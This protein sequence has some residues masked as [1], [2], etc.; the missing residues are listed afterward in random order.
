M[1][2]IIAFLMIISLFLVIG[3]SS[4]NSSES[5]SEPVLDNV[6]VMENDVEDT[7]TP[8]VVEPE[9][10]VDETISVDPTV[11]KLADKAASVKSIY[12]EYNEFK[13]GSTGYFAYVW[14]KDD[15]MKQEFPKRSGVYSANEK[16]DTAYID[17]ANKDAIAFC[18]KASN[19][20]TDEL[21]QEVSVSYNQ[22]IVETPFDVLEDAKAGKVVRNEMKENRDTKVV[23]IDMGENTV[24]TIWI[25]TYKGLPI[26]YEIVKEK[27]GGSL[28]KLR[29]VTFANLNY[30]AVS[31]SEV[32]KD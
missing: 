31:E 30:N 22:F 5:I 16:F 27:S 7:K 19:C 15:L 29:S 17:L 9:E 25:E 2:K 3:C 6:E 18:E 4:D 1:K 20:E 23:E 28:E 21:G 8:S 26:Y 11:S 13:A 14:L 10:V 24:K 12:Y 32:S